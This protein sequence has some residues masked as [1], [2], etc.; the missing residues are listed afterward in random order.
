MGWKLADK[1]PPESWIVQRRGSIPRKRVKGKIFG[2]E[3]TVRV[4]TGGDR[5]GEIV[6]SRTSKTP[7]DLYALSGGLE[8]PI[9]RIY[10]PH[11]TDV[12]PSGKPEIAGNNGEPHSGPAAEKAIATVTGCV[13]K[14]KPN[15]L[16]PKQD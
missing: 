12:L 13:Q 6:I 16:R 7:D 10:A 14:V 5:A 9:A 4:M 8:T 3:A 11:G 2:S 15:L 1:T